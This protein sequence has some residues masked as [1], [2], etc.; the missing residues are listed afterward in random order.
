VKEMPIA[1]SARGYFEPGSA[2]C[3][4]LEAMSIA[5]I[6]A[7]SDAEIYELMEVGPEEH[8]KGLEWTW[9]ESAKS[10][11]NEW[12]ERLVAD[13][14]AGRMKVVTDQ[15]ELRRQW[16]RDQDGDGES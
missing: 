4:Q 8:V 3:N 1:P 15:A 9:R 5:E 16:E 14:A 11:T 7:M 12:H 2:K 13:R 10:H 6:D